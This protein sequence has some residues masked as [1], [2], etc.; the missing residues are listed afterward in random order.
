MGGFG[1]GSDPLAGEPG[2]VDG[3]PVRVPILDRAAGESGRG[4]AGDCL[5]DASRT[6]GEAVFEVG[7]DR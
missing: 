4:S 5:G 7:A 3:L 1:G 2:V 6:R